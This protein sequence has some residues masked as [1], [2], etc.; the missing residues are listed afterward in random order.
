M[1]PD[2]LCPGGSAPWTGRW[3]PLSPAGRVE[4]C[5]P[6]LPLRLFSSTQRSRSVLTPR[7][8]HPEVSGPHPQRFLCF[9]APASEGFDRSFVGNLAGIFRKS[10]PP[11]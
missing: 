7:W 11:A 9:W 6:S 8:P 1:G 3:S 2:H 4:L 5:F 10:F